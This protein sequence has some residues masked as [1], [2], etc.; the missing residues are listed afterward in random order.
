MTANRSP[1]LIVGSV[2]VGALVAVALLAP[3]IAPYDAHA[4]TGPA[5]ASP[6][7]KHLLGTNDAG[8][9]TFSPLV[10]GPVAPYSVV[11]GGP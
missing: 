7:G 6:T 5:L 11:S 9:D 4:I 2:I 3:L 10:L 1:L 8:S